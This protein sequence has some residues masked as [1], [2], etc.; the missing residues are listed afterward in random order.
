MPSNQAIG[1]ENKVEEW[2]QW[3]QHVLAASTRK[4]PWRRGLDEVDAVD[5]GIWLRRGW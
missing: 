4:L 2:T 1:G 3:T 5:E